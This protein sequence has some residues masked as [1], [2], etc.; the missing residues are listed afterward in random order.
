MATKINS[1]NQMNSKN[2]KNRLLATILAFT[3]GFFGAH[4]IYLQ[5]PKWQALLHFSTAVLGIFSVVNLIKIDWEFGLLWLGAGIGMLGLTTAYFTTMFYALTPVWRWQ[6]YLNKNINKNH[7]NIKNNKNN[8]EATAEDN[9]IEAAGV[10]MAI[11]SLMLAM[12]SLM[13]F[14]AL[15]F[16]RY[17]ESS[18]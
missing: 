2:S 1:K 8:K 10:F 11:L 13:A 14:I 9:K 7:I 12:G 4:L 17:F 18:I 6:N 16:Q 15:G 5:K 3:L